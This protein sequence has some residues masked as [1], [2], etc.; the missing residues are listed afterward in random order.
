MTARRILGARAQEAIVE[1]RAA[2]AD[3]LRRIGYLVGD[4]RGRDRGGGDSYFEKDL[5]LTRPALLSRVAAELEDELPESSDRIAASAPASVALATTLSLRSG[6]PM[7]FVNRRDGSVVGDA[8]PDAQ[9]VLVLDVILT[10]GLASEEL[11][12]LRSA[13]MNPILALTLLDRGRGGRA[14]VE[15]AGTPVR[16]LFDERDLVGG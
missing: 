6:I 9:V 2:L 16:A 12:I 3:D 7:L 13:G 15:S 8:F 10:G 1:D 5:V 11:E 4:L 14:N